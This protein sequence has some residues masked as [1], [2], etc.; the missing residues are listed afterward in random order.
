M[1]RLL[2]RQIERLGLTTEA[3][4]DAGQWRQVLERVSASYTQS[5]EA[6]QIAG[7]AI[8]IASREMR[9]LH[10]RDRTHNEQLEQRVRERTAELE[11]A[12]LAARES[13]ARFR[14]LTEL[15][16]DWYWEQDAEF[17]FVDTGHAIDRR[18]R[19]NQDDPSGKRRWELPTL[20]MTEADWTGHRVILDARQPFHDLELCRMS[21]DGSLRWLSV[22]GEPIFGPD[23]TFKG[24]RGIGKDI[25]GRKRAEEQI[26]S[27]ALQQRLIAEFGQQALAG[28]DLALVLQSAA[29]LVAGTLAADCSAV[30]AFEPAPPQLVYRA[31]VGWPR[32]W[33][34]TYVVGLVPGDRVERVVS[35]RE[36][37]V[38]DDYA[39]M[40]LD[41]G[42]PLI[43]FGIRSGV[44]VPI[45]GTG[46][47]LG[48][49]TAHTRELRR[50]IED[51]LSFLRSVAN[52]LATAIERKFAEDQL[53][54][55]AQFD[56]VTGLPNRHVFRDRFREALVQAER[57]DWIAGMLFV[58]LDRFKAVNDTFGHAV[59]DKLLNAVA[60]RLEGCVGASDTLARLSGDEFAVVLNSIDSGT[61]AGLVAQKIIQVLAAP[62]EIE[63]HEAYVSA[64]VGIALYPADGSTAEE[65]LKNADTAMYRAKQQGRNGYQFY[66]PQMKQ[67]L[68]ERLR[69]EAGLRG[70]L[71]RREFMLHYQPKV[72][73]DTGMI[74]GFEA[75]LRWQHEGRLVPP[76]EFIPILEETGLI[77]PVGEWVLRSVCEQLSHWRARGIAPRPVAVNLSARQFQRQSLVSVVEEILR[78]TAV[79]PELLEL[80]LT[81]SLLMSDAEEAVQML[82]ELKR[83]GVRLAVDDFG[84]GYSSF[85]YLKR[86]PLDTLKIDRAFISDA[87]TNPDDANITVSIIN[88]AHSMRLKVVAEGVETQGQLN[89]LRLHGCDEI[90]GYYFARPS[91]VAECTQALL[92]DRALQQSEPSSHPHPAPAGPR[93]LG[94]SRPARRGQ[95]PSTG[96]DQSAGALVT[97]F[98]NERR[99]LETR[100]V[101]FRQPS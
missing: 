25:T 27:N 51:D 76:A 41:A 98:H 37:L 57:H 7:H 70:A 85:A 67:R 96:I 49:L 95:S 44:H 42:S 86:F 47:V 23:G 79:A 94:P 5:D 53:T 84:T 72:Q 18:S 1:H 31:V 30:L 58:D 90:Q 80:E 2:T 34:E 60:T 99:K 55:L 26:R 75:L 17:R 36:P 39:E 43:E 92:E 22:S 82:R 63:H 35:R 28:G 52:I 81:E 78:E 66:L 32:E 62:F 10:D 3:P 97:D 74:S 93:R 68:M 29:E 48:M 21:A 6:R 16:S 100:P 91:P 4:P 13:E 45:F 11:E 19:N 59:G 38:V 40:Q 15:S 56:T 14:S 87:V 77:V 73:L 24:Y 54:R 83:L 65:L 9:E 71:D 50:F 64:S 33:T 12:E 46:G 20:N 69:L 89:F 88:L 8:E 61:D 101:H